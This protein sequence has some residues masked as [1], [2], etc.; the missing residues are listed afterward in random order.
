MD[1]NGDALYI[2]TFTLRGNQMRLKVAL[3]TV[4]VAVQRE[5]AHVKADGLVLNMLQ[6][7]N[8]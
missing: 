3:P 7:V 4:S 8:I 1:D 6:N 5:V 2:F